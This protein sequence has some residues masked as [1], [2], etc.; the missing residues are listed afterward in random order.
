[1]CSP[2]SLLDSKLINYFRKVYHVM[3]INK[4]FFLSPFNFP[5]SQKVIKFEIISLKSHIVS[6]SLSV[7]ILGQRSLAGYCPWGC[8]EWDMIGHTYTYT[9]KN[10]RDKCP[11][12]TN[13]SY[14]VQC[15]LLGCVQMYIFIK[16]LE[17]C[18]GDDARGCQCPFVLCLHP[19]GCLRRG[20]WECKSI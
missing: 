3:T 20:W 8:T 16:H 9:H 15:Q 2:L 7:S 17:E 18:M 1:M 12:E 13:T 10:K 6:L 11:H 4:G 19:Q 14:R 5:F